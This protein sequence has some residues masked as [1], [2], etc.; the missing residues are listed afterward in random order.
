MRVS[1]DPA[2][3]TTGADEGEG[4]AGSPASRR[5]PLWLSLLFGI[6]LTL[7]LALERGRASLLI[8]PP[9]RGSKDPMAIALRLL[10][11]LLVSL[12]AEAQPSQVGVVEIRRSIEAYALERHIRVESLDPESIVDRS[13]GMGVGAVNVSIV[14]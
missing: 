7:R 11:P 12:R 13:T 3:A 9:T 8:A 14:E 2:T 4:R 5:D 6:G 1:R 10:I